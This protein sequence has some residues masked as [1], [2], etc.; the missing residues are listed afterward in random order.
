MDAPFS[1][2]GRTDPHTRLRSSEVPG[3]R[4]E[5][6]DRTQRRRLGL[7]LFGFDD[8]GEFGFI[9]IHVPGEHAKRAAMFH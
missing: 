4:Y 7:V 8:R 2:S 9:A 6:P 3:C 5:F 1:P